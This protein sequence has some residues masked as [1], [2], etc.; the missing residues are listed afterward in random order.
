MYRRRV[1]SCGFVTS[2]A[3]LVVVFLTASL[4]FPGLFHG[5]PAINGLLSG[6]HFSPP[7]SSSAGT[8][9]QSYPCT[10]GCWIDGA[11]TTQSALGGIWAE[12]EVPNNP[13]IGYDEPIPLIYFWNGL[14]E[15]SGASGCESSS[16]LQPLLVWGG[17]GYCKG[18]GEY[19]AIQSA[20]YTAA[21]NV[22]CTN[23]L[24]VN[25]GNWIVGNITSGAPG[26]PA[27]SG[28]TCSWAVITEDLNTG[29]KVILSCST[30]YYTTATQTS[31]LCNVPV[32]TWAA[33]LLE[34]YD[35]NCD[36]YPSGGSTPFE[37]SVYNTAH[38][39]LAG[40]WSPEVY[41]PGCGAGASA[42]GHTV[43]T[44]YLDY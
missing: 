26:N 17:D 44:I 14:E 38:S 9:P 25:V 21:G 15:C 22:Y 10:F 28:N 37:A 11:Y 35:I 16:L 7:S 30:S 29:A 20:I 4:S 3:T 6:D 5:A 2:V 1:V 12:W 23:A 41:T 43:E 18:T 19:W 42:S 13:T 8:P 27:C 33:T 32:R 39:I 31:Q 34:V 36:Q 40:T 24:Q